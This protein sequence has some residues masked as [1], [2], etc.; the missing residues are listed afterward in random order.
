MPD[1][2][3]VLLIMTDQQR[4]D[5]LGCYGCKGIFSP[6]ID[7]LAEEGALFENC[8]V[9]NPICTPSRASIFTGRPL[10][11]HGVNRL[12]DI[13]PANQILFPS[14]LQEKGYQTAL[15]GKLHISRAVYERDHRNVNDGFDVYDWCH[16]P[17]LFLDGR[18]N[19]Y[20]KW[21]RETH[22]EFYRTLKHEGRK[23]KNI[24]QEV[25]F[26]RWAAD[27]TIE[28]I[29]NRDPSRPFFCMMSLFDPHGPYTDYPKEALQW[30]DEDKLPNV[31]RQEG[32]AHTKSIGVLREHEEGH[33]GNYHN[34][35]DE[36][37]HQMR[38]GYFASIAFLDMQVGRVLDF[39]DELRI[40]EETLV[41]FV[42]DHGD[43]L[44]DHELLA[45]GAFFY[46]AC[47]KVPLIIRYPG[48][49]KGGLRVDEL[50]QPHDLAA[51]IL[52]QA[53]FARE[54]LNK[55]MPDSINLIDILID[56]KEKYIRN[57]AVCM[58]RNSGLST[59][60]GRGYFDPPVCGT[61]IRDKRYKLNV[62]HS[63]D[64]EIEEE[65]GELYDMLEDPAEMNNLW[66]DR[67]FQKI[68]MMLLK[69]L[70][71][72][73][74]CCDFRYNGLRSGECSPVWKSMV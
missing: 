49:V 37:L 52:A 42:S 26:T 35:S 62:Y 69:R 18:F 11:G 12:Y 53:G 60:I 31:V 23:L 58:Y 36:D 72:W 44:G 56:N 13:M 73:L 47:T 70:I 74:V 71:D 54:E 25:H 5:S 6:N 16:E 64:M 55:I 9:N 39:L 43:M 4:F 15:I 68:K 28:Y 57:Y 14:M 27:R 40:A 50:V 21:L 34:Y 59:G 46:D 51:T 1:M 22:P 66:H 2:P 19:A 67:S 63:T 41:F 10:P 3:N 24:P 61:M 33:M 45:K 32:E 30:I 48:V 17:A 38:I 20:G 7:R 29:K 65:Q 8:Y